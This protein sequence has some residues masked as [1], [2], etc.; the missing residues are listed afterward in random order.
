MRFFD[1][2]TNPPV[3]FG[4]IDSIDEVPLLAD[5]WPLVLSTVDAD[6]LLLSTIFDEN[7]RV[8]E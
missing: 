5:N 4:T 1:P 6:N 7:D 3:Y 2:L 8:D